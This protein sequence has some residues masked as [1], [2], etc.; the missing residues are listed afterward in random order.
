MSSLPASR[1]TTRNAAVT[2]LLSLALA[3]G[4]LLGASGAR[5]DGV[6]ANPPTIPP[7]TLAPL[8]LGGTATTGPKAGS[9]ATPTAHTTPTT[10]AASAG[11]SYEKAKTLITAKDWTGAGAALLEADKLQPNNADV[12]NLL[13]FTNRKLGNLDK[14]LAYYASALKID[15]NHVGAHEYLGETYL[16]LNNSVKAKAE[17]ASLKKLCGVKCEQYLD[18]SK[19]ITSYK[20]TPTT[21]KK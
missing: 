7:T 18:L 21:K 12:Q 19:A 5:A 8:S 10:I 3:G 15:P 11:A 4:L 14:A 1:T 2:G 13:G 16:L 6:D 20:P 17:L 9:P